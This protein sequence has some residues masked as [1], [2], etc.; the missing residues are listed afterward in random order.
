MKTIRD[1]LEDHPFFSDYPKDYLETISGC[2]RNAAYKAG[3]SIAKEGDPADYFFLITRGRVRIEMQQPAGKAISI[4]TLSDGEIIGWSWIFPPYKW[5]FHVHAITDVG[6][7]AMD[8]A[9]LRQKCE[10]DHTLGYT[11]MKSFASILSERLKHSR[12]QCMDVYGVSDDA[13]TSK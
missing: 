10:T 7:I 3:E 13:S 11:L 4:Q 12:Y 2:G 5:S 9:C 6:V 1:R 8:G